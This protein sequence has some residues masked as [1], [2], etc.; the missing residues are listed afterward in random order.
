M[1]AIK[2]MITGALF[3]LL[4]PMMSLMDVGFSGFIS[5]CSNMQF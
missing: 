1:R 2:F 5:A 3:I 4:G